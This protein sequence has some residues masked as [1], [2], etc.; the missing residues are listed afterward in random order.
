[1]KIAVTGIGLVTPLGLCSQT[2]LEHSRAGNSAIGPLTRFDVTG[3]ACTAAAEVPEFE[4]VNLLRLPKN[5]KYMTRPVQ[6]AMYAAIEALRLGALPVNLLPPERFAIYTGS[7]NTGLEYDEFFKALS[8]AWA[9]DREY[10]YKHLGGRPT[11]LIDAFF[12]LRTLSN[13]GV[14]LLS[15]ELDARGPNGNFVHSDT[16]SAMALESAC[17]DLMEGHCDVALA[18]GYDSLLRPSIFLAYA[19]A[20]HLSPSPHTTAYRPFDERRD[21]LVPGEGASFLLLERYEDARARNAEILGVING[22]SCTMQTT[23]NKPHTHSLQHVKD[24]IAA[25]LADG[26]EI[27]FVVARGIGTRDGDEREAA[28]LAA[29]VGPDIP[30]TA[31]KSATGYL[32]A[33]TATVELGLGLLCAREHFLPAIARTELRDQ[34]CSLNLATKPRDLGED[35]ATGLFLS[36]SWGGQATAILA[37]AVCD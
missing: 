5:I 20:G 22:I 26:P 9:D 12:S 31:F 15:A 6:C 1:M 2:N 14:G 25:V 8:L 19:A 18:G 30:V 4:L 17:D 24:G 23:E 33:A 35:G 10:D 37:S 3:H 11:R 32:G 7:G 28:D 16:A 34:A 27:D 21:G 13:V 29:A 36:E